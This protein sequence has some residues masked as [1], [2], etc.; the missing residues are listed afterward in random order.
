MS[1]TTNQPLGLIETFKQ[2]HSVK[3]YKGKN[4]TQEQIE[5]I[6]QSITEANTLQTPFHSEGV[7]VSTTEPGLARFGSITNEAGWIVLKLKK[8]EDNKQNEE[9][10]RK[11]VIDVSYIAQHVVMKLASNNINTSWV[12]GTFDENEA[13]KRFQGY[14][15]PAVIAYGIEVKDVPFV[16][17]M[18]NKIGSRTSRMQLNQLFFDDVN[19][20][21]VSENDFDDSK[22]EKNA[23]IYPPY[24]KDFLESIRLGP[25]ALNQ[26]PWRFVLSGKDVHFFDYKNNSYSQFDIGIALAN[27]D[28]LKEIRGGHCDFEIK[29]PAPKFAQ[30]NGTYMTTVVYQE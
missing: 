3:A 7:E 23:P 9:I 28:L 6:A 26:Q 5:F 11:R 18:F 1:T 12:G 4:L 10:E 22:K 8:T 21:F 13:E 14:K 19:N 29:D 2:R 27:L 30:I 24:L 17:K 15:I 16:R 25:S 20:R